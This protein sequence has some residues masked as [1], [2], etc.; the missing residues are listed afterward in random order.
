MNDLRFTK[1]VVA[2]PWYSEHD[3]MSNDAYWQQ[4]YLKDQ[5]SLTYLYAEGFSPNLRK[6]LISFS[7]LESHIADPQALLIYHHG[8]Y[9]VQGEEILKRAK[10]V[11]SMKYH[12]ITPASFYRGYDAASTFATEKGRE[13]TGRILA[14]NRIALYMGASQYNIEDL[15]SYGFPLS[16]TAAIA[17]FTQTRDFDEVEPDPA[18]TRILKDSARK[19]LLFVGRVVPNK[20]HA[21]LLKV[22]DRYISFYGADVCLHIIGGLAMGEDV[23]FIEL[24]N[25]LADLRLADNVKFHQ[26]VGLPGLKAFYQNCDVFLLL[27]EHEGFCVPILESQHMGLPIVALD[28]AAIKETLG[29]GQLIYDEL[30]Y[31]FF[32]CAVRHVASNDALRQDLKASGYTNA[33]KYRPEILLKKTLDCLRAV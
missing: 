5:G 27:S 7:E 2:I 1:V 3:A 10:C 25:I 6:R 17:P 21:H 8:V 12:N 18:I 4:Q 15:R 20:G 29:P 30:D 24:E 22:V 13:Q 26:K 9:W 23:Y 14:M 32:A 11:I 33:E 28:R 31:D 19:N 16:D